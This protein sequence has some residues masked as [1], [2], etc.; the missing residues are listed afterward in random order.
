MRRWRVS[1]MAARLILIL[2]PVLACSGLPSW[3]QSG[4][5]QG[6][7]RGTA[8]RVSAHSD[9]SGSLTAADRD[10][11]R[12][13]VESSGRLVVYSSGSADTVGRLED[14]RGSRL[15]TDN[16]SGTGRNFRIGR[17]I[18]AGTYYLQVRGRGSS[19]GAYTLHVRF[20]ESSPPPPPDGDD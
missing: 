18:T 3:A 13:A 2:V 15:A 12:I 14:S 6:S 19:T 10:Y 9:T 7:T 8:A 5:D 1:G 4:E 17:D 20:E 11:F 16:D